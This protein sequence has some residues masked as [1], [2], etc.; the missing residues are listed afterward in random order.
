MAELSQATEWNSPAVIIDALKVAA[1]YVGNAMKEPWSSKFR[2]FKL[3]N[4]VADK[5]TRLEG[6]LAILQGIG[7]EIST[8][9]QEF[10]A[11]IPVSVDLEQMNQ[12]ISQL[13]DDLNHR[14]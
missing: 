9:G 1:K 2:S 12:L 6:G 14:R 11:I 13:I 4:Q 7:F 3:S 5:I 10:R 8:T